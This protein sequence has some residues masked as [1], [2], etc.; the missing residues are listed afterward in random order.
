MSSYWFRNGL[1]HTMDD[2]RPWAESL[3]VHDELIAFVGSDAEARSHL[4]SGTEEVDLEGG[5]LMPGFISGHDHFI[6]GALSKIG[7]SLENLHGKDA[8]LDEIR[9]YVEAHPDREVIRGHGW[10]QFTF[11]GEQPHRTWLDA[12]TDTR[13][14]FL[15]SYE[16]HDVWANT[17]AFVAAGIDASTPDPHPPTS[18]FF[19]D[20]DGFPAGTCCEGSWLPLAIKLG[21]YSME[22]IR[23]AMD[24]TMT[25]APSR[26]ITSYFDAGTLLSSRRLDREVFA[27]LKQ[28]DENGELPVRI[29][30][31]AGFLRDGERE[32]ERVIESAREF[33]AAVQSENISITTI[34]MFLDGVGPAH[35]ASMLEPYLD[36]PHTGGW[37]VPPEFAVRMS[38]QANLAGFDTHIHACGDAAVRAALD[39]FEHVATNHPQLSPRNTVCHLEFC[40]PDDV[41]R[42]AELGVTANG[43]PLWGTDYLGEFIDAYPSL[44]GEERF[45]RDY[46]PYGSIVRTGATV[47]F[48]SDCPG[49]AVDE[50]APLV[51]IEAAVTR[52]RPGRPDDRPAGGHE[53]VSLA[54]ALRCYTI[55]AAR[56]LRLEGVTGSIEVGKRADL[57]QLAR[58]PFSVPS[59]EIHAIPIVRTLF[60]GRITHG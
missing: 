12:V 33:Q 7:V 13:P 46:L 17:A 25:P 5:F 18:F 19:R 36:E 23:E 55:N 27:E 2:R 31:S 39:A 58:N 22:S 1:I 9:R 47:T 45:R 32:P 3:V 41:P 4:R 59:H 34:K 54:D 16:V 48:G 26:G 42:F 20:S 30:G 40:H 35:T 10:T 44:V 51:Q 11:G 21:M 38:E 6:G 52:R 28:L 37:M 43:T 49:V 53:Q 14:A 50:I 24:L 57:V 60:G 8:V 56:A 29:V 15:H